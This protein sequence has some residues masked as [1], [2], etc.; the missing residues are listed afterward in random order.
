MKRSII[1]LNENWKFTKSDEERIWYKAL[2]DSKWEDVNIPHDWSIKYPFSTDYSSGTGY[3]CGGI[4]CYRKTFYVPKELKEKKFYLNFDGVYNNSQVWC[5]SNYLGARPFGYISF[6]YDITHCI[7]FENENVISVRVAHTQ[8]TDSRWFTG[9]GIYRDVKLIVTDKTHFEEHGVFVT[10][11]EISPEYAKIKIDYQT[12]AKSSFKIESEIFDGDELVKS[13]NTDKNIEEIGIE[14]PKLWSTDSPNLYTLVSKLYENDELVDEV[15]TKFGIREIKFTP[16]KGFFLNGVSMKIKG[17]CLHHDAGCLGAAVPKEVWTHRLSKLKASGC[18]ALRTA[19]N[20]TATDFLE[21]CD[22]LGFMVMEEAFDEW[23][24]SKNK[25]WQGHNVYPPKN[26]GYSQD[27]PQW[28]ETD[29]KEMVR[30]D[31]NHP[32]VTMWS[33]GNEI[34]YPNDPYVHPLFEEMTG[35]NDKNKP[36]AERIYDKNRPNAER[37]VDISE[38][39]AKYVKECDT[40]RPVTA[41][42]A[43]PELSNKTGY[44]NALDAIG[45]NYKEHIYPEYHQDHPEKVLLGTEN[46]HEYSAWTVVRDNDYICAQFVWSVSDFL[47]EATGWPIRCSGT[48]LF[49]LANNPKWTFYYRQ[50]LWQEKPVM[51]IGIEKDKFEE[52][53]HWNPKVSHWNWE[54]GKTIEVLTC[55]NAQETELFLN[56]KSLGKINTSEECFDRWQ[57]PFEAGDLLAV[58]YTDGKKVSEY[59][60][61]TAK[62]ATKVVA[63]S[64][65]AKIQK[66]EKVAIIDISILDEDGTLVASNDSRERLHIIT[67]ENLSILGIENG[68]IADTEQYAQNHRRVFGGKMTVYVRAEKQGKGIV[69]II[70]ENLTDTFVEIEVYSRL[71]P[72]P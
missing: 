6:T 69:K 57:V 71:S 20:P 67:N 4:A 50:V 16:D 48:G 72:K 70:S 58:G 13:S 26:F 2:D 66:D 12:T 5:N 8:L 39:L 33:I 3:V 1:N 25:W 49:D 52:Y 45:Y 35:N 30:R 59:K 27:F 7:D 17:M 36:E 21:V 64:N 40:T 44:G 56:G 51:Y 68:D 18:N 29:L 53:S 43:F 60:I 55:T 19:H 61:V 32:C 28:A 62:K 54:N 41:A 23:E 47:G 14:N 24:M 10:T 38:R 9:S 22:E 34:D 65:V 11:P 63:K 15:S 31:R 46:G 42:L 37:L